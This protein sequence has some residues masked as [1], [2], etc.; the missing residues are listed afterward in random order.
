MIEEQVIPIDFGQGIDTKTNPKLV[1]AGRLLLLENG[2]FT[3]P[4]EVGKRNGYDAL[5]SAIVGGGNLVAPQMV[6]AYNNEL[7]LAD[8]GSLY[9]YSPQLLG[10]V[11]R[12]PY[13]STDVTETL[14]TNQ[15][16]V[17]GYSDS[18]V[19]AN[20]ALYA[21]C[22]ANTGDQGTFASVVDLNSNTTLLAQ[23]SL[24]SLPSSGVFSHPKCIVLGSSALGVLYLN[25]SNELVIRIL[26]S[27]LGAGTTFGGEIVLGSDIANNGDNI[28]FDVD[29]LATGAVVAYGG[30][31]SFSGTPNKV[32]TLTIDT[33]GT[34]IHTSTQSS[35]GEPIAVTLCVDPTN[36]NVWVYWFDNTTSTAEPAY[37]LILSPTLG[38]VLAQTTIGTFSRLTLFSIQS[39]STTSQ[40]LY[41]SNQVYNSTTNSFIDE[42][43]VVTV[44]STGTIGSVNPYL[45]GV[46]PASK[47]FTIGSQAYMV[48]LY[49]GT[50][51]SPVQSTYF[52]IQLSNQVVAAR[53][54][55]GT[56]SPNY[57]DGHLFHINLFTSTVALFAASVSYQTVTDQSLIFTLV[58]CF[59]TRLDFA[60]QRA[61][62][63]TLS[64]QILALNGALVSMYDGQSCTEL[65]FN[66]FPEIRAAI[67]STTGGFILGGGSSPIFFAYTYYAVYQWYD[68]QGNFHQSAPSFPV[69]VNIASGMTNSVR[70]FVSMCYLTQKTGINVA[71]FRTEAGQTIARL[72]TDP[73]NISPNDPTQDFLDFT[74]TLAD[75]S[76]QGNLELYTTGNVVDNSSPP[77]SMV[78]ESHNNRLWMVDAENPNTIQYSKTFTNGVGLSM[79]NLLLLQ[80]DPKGGDIQGMAEMDE[81]MVILKTTT[82]FFFVG[83]GAN[84]T[85]TGST[86]TVPQAIPS[87]S[88]CNSLKSIISLP[89]G[90]IFKGPKGI[91][92]LDRSLNVK[93]IGSEVEAYNTQN[94]TAATLITDKSQVRFLTSA[95]ST[96]VYDYLFNQWGTFTNHLGYAA[97]NWLGLYVYVRTDGSV[98]QEDPTSCL[99]GSTSYKLRAQLSWLALA[100]VQGFQRVRRLGMLGDFVNGSSAGHGVQVSAAYD[101][102]PTFSAPIQFLFGAANASGA[103]RYRERLPV[104]KCTAITLLIEEITTGAS[105][106]TM[107]LSNMGF[108]AGVK[109]GLARFP[110]GQSNG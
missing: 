12:G 19:L 52:V 4:K 67:T 66:L 64:S 29:T 89:I 41:F 61:Y 103:L 110:A 14:V 23:F 60:S 11:N 71:I 94:I 69:T 95:G 26:S 30:S 100:S 1:V 46:V 62:R 85:G 49:F 50:I 93:Y 97:D 42:T 38:S 80:M 86:L 40:T 99:D 25:V 10:W 76:I 15:G 108:E 21:W 35:A 13:V 84:D 63:A 37:Y 101:F 54:F 59:S 72:V 18:A 8:S 9:S 28:A 58:G 31:T 73:F 34:V 90:T 2:L 65:G 81:K 22:S 74:D 7:I 56:A 78:M 68:A 36:G 5:P 45:V 57:F 77:A 82:P 70:L 47:V 55:S 17:K 33:A 105:G 3:A 96:I 79:S 87:D 104:Q 44:S 107:S 48:F 6:K 51:S 88:G 39:I 102:N 109:R 98:Y 91:Y 106:E 32:V 53:L 24:A 43:R 75:L 16:S 92:L 83:D 27:T 20:I